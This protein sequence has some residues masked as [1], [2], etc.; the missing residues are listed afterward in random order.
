[1][2]GN[3]VNAIPGSPSVAI[4]LTV[5][6]FSNIGQFTL[7]IMFDTTRIRF[8]S[9]ATN[10]SLAG[11][12]ITYTPPVGNTRGKLVFTW[13]GASNF[14]MPD[15]SSLANLVFSYVSGTEILSWTYSSGP[16]CQY[17]RYV[18]ATLSTLNDDPKYRFYING[19]ISNRS[20]PVSYAPI[21]AMAAAGPVPLPVTAN[22]FS[23]IGAF[24]LYLEYDPAILT[25]QNSFIKNSAFG[26]SFQV[27]NNPGNGGKMLIVIQWYGNEVTLANGSVICTLNFTYTSTVGASCALT[28]YDIGPSCEYA[29][30]SYI[31][32]DLPAADYY[33]NGVVAPP[34]TADFIADNLTPLKNEP[35]LLTDLTTGAPTS[36]NWSFDRPGTGNLTIP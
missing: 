28:W 4:P 1:M 10:P 18:G 29:D 3:V 32:I 9:A 22:G 20:A 5:N 26:S 15:G 16:V 2:A 19:G 13:T 31:L 35:V 25:Y 33:H 7:T 17:K 8:V 30:A 24:T 11:M 12:A 36:W 23:G 27:G 14:S 6:G 21:V 34:L